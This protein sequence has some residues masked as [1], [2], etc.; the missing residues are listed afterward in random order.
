MKRGRT[1]EREVQMWSK[2]VVGCRAGVTW[3]GGGSSE[4]K[5]EEVGFGKS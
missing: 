4:V 5:V 2:T 3:R 1:V